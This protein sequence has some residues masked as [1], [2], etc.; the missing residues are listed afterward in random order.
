MC[1]HPFLDRPILRQKCSL[2]LGTSQTPKAYPFA[3]KYTFSYLLM[4]Q[5]AVPKRK[6]PRNTTRYPTQT[7]RRTKVQVGQADAAADTVD[8]QAAAAL[9]AAWTPVLASSCVLWIN[10]WYRA[11]YTTHP[12]ES[13]RLQ[14]CTPMAVLQLKQRPTYWA[15]HP[16]IEDLAARSTTVP[17]ALQQCERRIPQTLRDMGYADGCVPN[18][19]NVRAPLDM[20]RDTRTMEAPVCALLPCLEKS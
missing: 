7:E 19:G 20:R 4:R 12:D 13:D 10:N 14:N 5:R 15:G 18:T 2:P 3:G 6:L 11:Q 16:V 8:E 1:C 9:K 17:R